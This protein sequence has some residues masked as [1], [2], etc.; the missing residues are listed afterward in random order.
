MKENILYKDGY[1]FIEYVSEKHSCFYVDAMRTFIP[2]SLLV[3]R[4]IASHMKSNMKFA[5]KC[6]DKLEGRI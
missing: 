2:M 6:L 3:G 1:C 5:Y 4:Y